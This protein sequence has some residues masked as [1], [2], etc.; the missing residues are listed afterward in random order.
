AENLKTTKFKNGDLIT[1]VTGDAAWVALTGPAYCWYNNDESTYKPLY[2]AL[3]N[4]FAASSDN[5]CPEGWHVPTNA[6]FETLEVFLGMTADQASEWEWR[7]TDQGS[8]M[9][10]TTGWGTTG[11]GTNSSGFSALP[12]GYRFYGNGSFNLAG[13]LGY[14][15]SS[16]EDG[17]A[18]IYRMLQND[19]DD[20]YKLGTTK[21]A[22]KSIR[23]VK[24][25]K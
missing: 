16:S 23:C 20:V 14:W 11:N 7:G 15:W 22:G 10:N 6:E 24:D 5:L 25:T 2:G 12:G 19:H 8:K 1:N 18:G 21:T 3:Y 13:T 4:W 17:G 9:K